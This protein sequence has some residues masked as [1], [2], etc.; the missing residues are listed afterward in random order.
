MGGVSASTVME[1][2]PLQSEKADSPM[3]VT[4][5]GMVI[6]VRLVIPEQILCGITS[7]SFPN[8]KEVTWLPKFQPL[9]FLAFHTTDVTLLQLEK[10]F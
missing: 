10:A 6:D 7:T 2:K 5:L 8:V 3:V 4:L 9:Q 1:V